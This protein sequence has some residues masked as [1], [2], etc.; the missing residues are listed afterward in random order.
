MNVLFIS[1]GNTETGINPI[2]KNQGESLKSNDI[3][4][5]YFTIKG[6]GLKSYLKH[7][8]PLKKYI[9]TNKFDIYHAHY[10]LS[11]MVAALSSAKPLIISLMGSDLYVS[12]LWLF[13][14]RIMY[15][16]KNINLIVK[17][18]NLK[19]K[20]NLENIYVIPN[21]VDVEKFSP[22]DMV[23]AKKE[24]NWKAQRYILFASDPQ[25]TEKNY[26]LAAQALEILNLE[27]Y[28]LVFLK[29]I[30]SEKV[31]SYLNGADL[32][33]LT[34]TYEG[35]P[36]IIKEAMACNCPIVST[37]VGDVEWVM[38]NTEGCFL[39]TFDPEEVAE[40]ID[41]AL[42]FAAKKGRTNGRDRIMELGLD[43]DSIA[44]RIINLYK[45]ILD[46]DS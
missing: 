41:L 31:T 29:N 6:K 36:N 22:V 4:V 8:S 23:D 37:N 46:S 18:E 17:S 15:H 44:K 1:S 33:L 7:I 21:G 13:I 43:S 39:T 25:R 20:L 11:G 40:K 19:Q 30:P 35:S 34:S 38:G 26:G 45:E 32:L 16:K 5:E 3:K 2:V 14:I 12:R 24:N 27:N 9:R 28:E 10:F 42:E